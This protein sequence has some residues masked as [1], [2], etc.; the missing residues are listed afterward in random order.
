[1]YGK[2]QVKEP[3]MKEAGKETAVQLSSTL[4]SRNPLGAATILLLTIA[5]CLTAANGDVAWERKSSS[6]GDMPTP[7]DGKQQTCCLILDIDKDG[8]DDFV[9]GER[10]HHPWSGRQRQCY[11][12]VGE[13]LSG[14]GSRGAGAL[15]AL[16]LPL[17]QELRR[18]QASRSD[19]WRL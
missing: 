11:L 9:V 15:K 10:T 18:Q 12:V 4:F 13:S 19:R 17:Y 2:S 6:T 16:D 8:I 3:Q 5:M 1:V 14:F 7:N